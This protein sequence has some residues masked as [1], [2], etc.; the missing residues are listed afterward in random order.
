M[1]NWNFFMKIAVIV[2]MLFGIVTTIQLGIHI[3][4]LQENVA[5]AQQRVDELNNQIGE[6]VDEIEQPVDRDYIMKIARESLNYHLPNEI[7]YY[8]DLQK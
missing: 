5:E 7:V 6:L 3:S 8:N 2:L 4:E 1:K